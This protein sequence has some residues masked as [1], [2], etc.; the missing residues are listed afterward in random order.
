MRG[1]QTKVFLK[2]YA[3]R[4]LSKEIVYRKKRGLSVPIGAW[5][6]GPL[7]DW[8]EA[9]LSHPGFYRLGIDRR[10]LGQLFDEHQRRVADHARALW[11]LLVLGEWLKAME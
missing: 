2:R 3:E 1:L 7:H 9:T 8:A 6:R 4:Y 10:A 5:L 11:A